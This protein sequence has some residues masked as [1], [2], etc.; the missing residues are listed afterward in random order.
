M[1]RFKLR[2]PL[3]FKCHLYN[4]VTLCCVLEALTK[5]FLAMNSKKKK[6]TLH[7]IN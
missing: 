7:N 4:A 2:S 6:N 3:I 5:R 1:P